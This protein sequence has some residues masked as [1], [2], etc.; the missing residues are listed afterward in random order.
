MAGLV[1]PPL[2][3][4]WVTSPVGPVPLLAG[5]G[6]TGGEVVGRFPWITVAEAGVEPDPALQL[7]G[8]YRLEGGLA[9][10]V[11]SAKSLS[12]FGAGRATNPRRR[13]PLHACRN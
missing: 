5:A 7:L 4:T 9:A 11:V 2:G 8:H 1:I 6:A 12:S 3:R 10:A 13:I